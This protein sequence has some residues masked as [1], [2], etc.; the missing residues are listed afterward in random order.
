L[1]AIASAIAASPGAPPGSLIFVSAEPGPIG[2][3]W[4]PIDGSVP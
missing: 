2:S 1:F 4:R 3:R